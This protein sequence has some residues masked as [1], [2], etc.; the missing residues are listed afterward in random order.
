MT[1]V[2]HIVNSL[3]TG[4]AELMLVRLLQGMD[5][6]RFEN[7]VVSLLRI[8]TYAG[9]LHR[10]GI[11]TETLDLRGAGSALG[12]LPRLRGITREVRPDLVQTW[13]YHSNLMG[14]LATRV[15]NDAPLVWSVHSSELDFSTYSIGLKLLFKLSARMSSVPSAIVCTSHVARQWHERHGFKPRRWQY[16]PAG[17]DIETFQPDALARERLRS[18]LGLRSNALI[19]GT[20]GRFH[21]QKDYPT[22][23]RAFAAL[24][25]EFPDAHALM[26][27][28]NVTTGNRG[29]TELAR[30]LGIGERVHMLG[31]RA[32]IASILA[33]MD[34]FVLASAFGESCPTVLLE[35]MACGVRCVA[36][37]LGDSARIVGDTGT[38]VPPRDPSAL[39]QACIEVL[40]NRDGGSGITA[41]DRIR[42]NYSLEHMAKAFGDLFDDLAGS[43]SSQAKDGAAH[44]GTELASGDHPT[45][46]MS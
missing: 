19:I 24:S 30:S 27:G 45:A 33:G 44:R 37:N 9:D 14:L 34:L 31:L 38:I 1:K 43:R 40:R 12:G 39:A 4:G 36:T 41:R 26:A 5:R 22:F 3:G 15:V 20:A 29:L 2:L 32:D 7:T 42:Q 11:R 10:L 25:R 46:S 17:V 28:V 23:L 16:V 18:E 6:R 13:M 21:P 35:A 8:D